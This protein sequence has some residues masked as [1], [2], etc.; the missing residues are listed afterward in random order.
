MTKV[1]DFLY[2]DESYFIRGGAFDIYKQFRNRHKEKVYQ[3]ALIEYLAGKGLKVEKEKQM[4][5]YFQGKKVGVYVP[6]IIINDRLFIELKCKPFIAQDDIKQ[7]WYYLKNSEYKVGYLINFGS[8][9]GVQI[10][11]RIYDTARDKKQ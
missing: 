4:P 6:D 1:D 3:Q 7:F 5:I 2:K 8:I 11:R 10:I 9:D